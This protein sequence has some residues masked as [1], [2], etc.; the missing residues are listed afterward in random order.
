RSRRVAPRATDRTAE[1]PD[2]KRGFPGVRALALKGV[3]KFKYRVF[4]I[5]HNLES[6]R[7]GSKHQASSIK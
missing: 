6:R 7:I 3:K 4:E 2:K 5:F 1:Q